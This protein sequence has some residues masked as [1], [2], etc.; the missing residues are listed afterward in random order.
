MS[1]YE[2]FQEAAAGGEEWCPKCDTF[3][4]PFWT[5]CKCVKEKSWKT[6]KNLEKAEPKLKTSEE[7]EKE[8][9]KAKEMMLWRLEGRYGSRE[10]A[11]KVYN[12]LIRGKYGN[13]IKE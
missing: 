4:V 3:Y 9:E 11:E 5:N 13:K 12:D 6:L 7:I 2:D 1:I 10:E 8:K